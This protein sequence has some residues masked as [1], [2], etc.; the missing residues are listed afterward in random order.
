MRVTLAAGI[1]KGDHMDAIVRDATM[2][3]AAEIARS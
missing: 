3:G 1:L 2:M